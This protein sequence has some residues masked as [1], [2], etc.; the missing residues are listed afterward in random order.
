MMLAQGME[1]RQITGYGMCVHAGD[2]TVMEWIAKGMVLLLSS[3]LAGRKMLGADSAAGAFTG[4][5]LPH[6]GT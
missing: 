1:V 5:R 4:Q 3:G 2:S 6:F